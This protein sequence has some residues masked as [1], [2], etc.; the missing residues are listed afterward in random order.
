MKLFMVHIG[1]IGRRER[2]KISGKFRPLM[3]KKWE[4]GAN[5]MHF[6]KSA[7]ATSA[8]LRNGLRV[9]ELAC[10]LAGGTTAARA[11]RAHGAG[12]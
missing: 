4:N 9:R 3:C 8:G 7:R 10:A 5:W 11:N 6:E 1:V 12:P 2:I